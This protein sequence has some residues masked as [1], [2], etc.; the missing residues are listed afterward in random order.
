MNPQLA[1]A[2]RG[3]IT[4]GKAIIVD[5]FRP[6]V[7]REFMYFA[8]AAVDMCWWYYSIEADRKDGTQCA[9]SRGQGAGQVSA[10]VDKGRDVARDL[11]GPDLRL[12]Q[13]CWQPVV[14]L[15]HVRP[16]SISGRKN[17]VSIEQTSPSRAAH[18]S[19]CY[20]HC[21]N[22]FCLIHKLS[23]ALAAAVRD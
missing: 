3:K 21:D 14:Y 12:E 5:Q 20:R 2:N 23:V 9:L 4:R 1:L 19:R 22:Q 16:R 10:E 17:Q 18:S 6:G 13:S 7:P 8:G 11:R 15:I